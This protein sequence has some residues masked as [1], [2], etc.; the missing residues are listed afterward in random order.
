[1]KNRMIFNSGFGKTPDREIVVYLR[2]LSR[3][4]FAGNQ[5]HEQLQLG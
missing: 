4:L 3:I 5:K 2:G 1:M